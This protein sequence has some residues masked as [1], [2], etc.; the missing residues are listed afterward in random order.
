M[1]FPVDLNPIVDQVILPALVPIVG[2]AITWAALKIAQLAHLPVSAA[3]REVLA[4]AINNGLAAVEKDENGKIPPVQAPQAVAK[5][6]SYVNTTVPGAL[7]T[8]GVSPAALGAVIATKIA[9]ADPA[10]APEPIAPALV[11][12]DAVGAT[13]LGGLPA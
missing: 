3:S 11:A 9:A 12:G 10:P 6:V 13:T 5:V 1:S 7:K 8:L 2:A 4:S